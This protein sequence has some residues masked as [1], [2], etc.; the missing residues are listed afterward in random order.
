MDQSWKYQSQK[1]LSVKSCPE[2]MMSRQSNAFIERSLKKKSQCPAEI[3]PSRIQYNVRQKNAALP[4]ISTC[5]VYYFTYH[6]PFIFDA[7]KEIHWT[8]LFSIVRPPGGSIPEFP[9]DIFYFPE[10]PNQKKIKFNP[11]KCFKFT[12]KCTWVFHHMVEENLEIQS[13]QMLKIDP[14]S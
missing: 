1:S 14:K 8:D 9:N 11:C 12:L 4:D 5:L 2:S 7:N 13:F 10:F 6:L 3:A